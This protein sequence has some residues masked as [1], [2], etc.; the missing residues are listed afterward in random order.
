MTSLAALAAPAA[1]S[2]KEVAIPAASSQ[3]SIQATAIPVCSDLANFDW[4]KEVVVIETSD[5]KAY[6]DPKR[7]EADGTYYV[8]PIAAANTSGLIHDLLESANVDDKKHFPFDD[9]DG[10]T[11]SYVLYYI[12]RHFDQEVEQIPT[13]L[14]KP[15]RE[16]ISTEDTN[17]LDLYLLEN[18]TVDKYKTLQNV[19]EASHRMRVKDLLALGAASCADM[20]SGKSVQEIRDMWGIVND[21]TPEEEQEI[22]ENNK[23]VDD[24]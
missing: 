9:I 13:P 2:G 15:L 8:I 1:S 6:S 7:A 5:H 12:L 14:N 23:R 4:E 21:F 3:T 10:K 17:F 11:M 24:R 16:I 18:G 22:E 20:M 19:L